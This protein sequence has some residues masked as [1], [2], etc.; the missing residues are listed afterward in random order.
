M[1]AVPILMVLCWTCFGCAGVATADVRD[2]KAALNDA[3]SFAQQGRYEEALQKHLW[4]HEN[5]LKY[6]P[7]M[8][9]VRLSFA[10]F[11]WI[12]LGEK[13]PKARAALVSIRDRDTGKVAGGQGS[14]ALFMDVAAI[15]DYLKEKPS[16]VEL[17]KTL[18]AKYPALAQQ[19]YHVA[20]PYLIAQHEYKICS[21]Y[22][23]DALQR[24]ERIQQMRTMHLDL[25]KKSYPRMEDYA[26][27][28]GYVE[29]L[30]AEET[31]RLIEILV[32]ADRQ[33]DAEKVRKQALAVHDDPRIRDAGKKDAQREQP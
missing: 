15:N 21:A 14:F 4:F 13:Y 32:G 26:R 10:L 25:A 9:G 27:I 16:T 5:A 2:P 28:E 30:F 11:Y 8:S 33:P 29:R 31:S 1:K 17:F 24:F 20:E 12:E 7:A 3:R 23:P 22:I 18:H 19:C 6:Q